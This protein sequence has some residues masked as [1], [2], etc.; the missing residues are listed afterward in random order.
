MESNVNFAHFFETGQYSDLILIINDSNKNSIQMNIHKIIVCSKSPMLHS[1]ISGN[2]IE[3]TESTNTII[4]PNALVTQDIIASMYGKTINSTNYEQWY[5]ELMWIICGD[6]LGIQQ[7]FRSLI[8]I[9]VP[10][11][12][13]ELLV[14]TTDTTNLPYN[15]KSEIILKNLPENYNLTK[16]P[17]HLINNLCKF[18]KLKISIVIRDD[19]LYIFCINS[20]FKKNIK[21]PFKPKLIAKLYDNQIIVTD[22]SGLI[23]ILDIYSTDIKKIFDYGADIDILSVSPNNKYII[24]NG[25]EDIS[26]IETST[27]N[28]KSTFKTKPIKVMACSSKYIATGDRN[29]TIYLWDICTTKLISK[30]KRTDYYKLTDKIWFKISTIMFSPD[31]TK[32]LFC[33]KNGDVIIKNMET[34]EISNHAIFV[35]PDKYYLNFSSNGK[36]LYYY[37]NNNGYDGLQVL[38][39]DNTEEKVKHKHNQKFTEKIKLYFHFYWKQ[40]MDKFKIF[41]FKD[42]V[43]E[44]TYYTNNTVRNYV[45][46]TLKS[47][48]N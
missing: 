7:N 10:E 41:N 8:N 38:T 21:L 3:A 14:H 9:Q 16:I 11:E 26:V 19:Q 36:S 40:Y 37:Q 32:L 39:L 43:V 15:K 35:Q 30:F 29:G 33:N 1:M 4:T 12:G 2:F 48:K 45:Q 23:Y 34:S 27:L 22:F 13:F 17:Q 44:T 5:Y 24:V 28:I 25:C 47:N 6:Y 46:N 20:Q 31:E 18:A 42:H